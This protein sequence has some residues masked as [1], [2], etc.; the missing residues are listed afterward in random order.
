MKKFISGLIIGA[1]LMGTVTF[2]A[3]NLTAIKST[4]KTTVSG[5][6]VT[7]NVVTISGAYYGDLKQLASNLGIKYS[8]D[9]KNKKITLGET[10]VA[11]KYTMKNPAPIGAM[12]TLN[13][14][15][16]F[17]EYKAQVSV[18]EILRGDEAL[19]LIKE[20][21]MFN[22]EAGEGYEYILA[23]INFKLLDIP[24]DKV[25]SLMG[26]SFKLV[27]DVGKEYDY[28]SVVQPDPVL[29]AKLYKGASNEGWAVFKVK[30]DDAK[31]LITFGRNYDGTGGI[32]FKTY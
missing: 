7:Q 11:N 3:S 2:A 15:D 10:P 28:A 18:K 19:K 6:A 21:N 1:L 17:E 29:D 25:F 32:W 16:M 8:V 27:S 24:G 26:I 30:I 14:K 23:K 22:D 5:K 4:F 12:Q 13:Y 20:A 9:T 31:P